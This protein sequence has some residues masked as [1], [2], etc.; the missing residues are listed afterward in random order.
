LIYL[1]YAKNILKSQTLD[2]YEI[3][4]QRVIIL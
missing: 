3:Q 2:Y 1:I 4:P